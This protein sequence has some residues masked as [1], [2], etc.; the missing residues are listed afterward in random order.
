[1]SKYIDADRM[2][3]ELKVAYEEAYEEVGVTEDALMDMVYKF[4]QALLMAAPAEDVAPVVRAEWETDGIAMV[5]SKCR[6]NLVVEQGDAEMNF[7]P[8]CGADMRA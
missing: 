5:C 7:C 6:K 3:R 2:M 8:N 4:V 1:M